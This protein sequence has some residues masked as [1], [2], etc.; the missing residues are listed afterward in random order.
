[1]ITTPVSSPPSEASARCA[2]RLEDFGRHLHRALDSLRRLQ[3]DHALGVDE[4][5]GQHFDVGDVLAPAAH[6][7]LGRNNGVA[8][9]GRLVGLGAEA[10]LDFAI[11]E[12]SA[13]STAGAA[14]R[15]RR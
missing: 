1:V 15:A 11:G 9:I 14:G 12:H 2:Q 8:R 7:A 13:R 5:V 6:E 4:V 10:N 3:L